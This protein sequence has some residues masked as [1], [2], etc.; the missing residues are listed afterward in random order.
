MEGNCAASEV[1]FLLSYPAYKE[2]ASLDS[3]E[4]VYVISPEG[5][6]E[7]LH[8]HAIHRHQTLD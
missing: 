8:G 2:T 1:F 7:L 4:N 3:G 6:L 5:L